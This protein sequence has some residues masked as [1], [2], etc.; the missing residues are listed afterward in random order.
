MST[1][2]GQ[3]PTLPARR[4]E[5]PLGDDS[6]RRRRALRVVLIKR[7]TS[8]TYAR[9]QREALPPS[10]SVRQHL[11]GT[12]SSR[13]TTGDSFGTLA[14]GR[15][16]L[17]LVELANSTTARTA[18]LCPAN[19]NAMMCNDLLQASVDANG[20]VATPTGRCWRLLCSLSYSKP[21]RCQ[22]EVGRA[23]SE[24]TNP[25]RRCPFTRS[26]HHHYTSG[27]P[28]VITAPA[29]PAA[30]VNSSAAPV[31]LLR[32]FTL[33]LAHSY[34]R[35]FHSGLA[36]SKSCSRAHSVKIPNSNLSFQQIH[37]V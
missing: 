35:L 6:A 4:D 37:H 30:E 14:P 33:S 25:S 23:K 22:I 11:C 9:R 3:L 27:L 34:S 20:I 12:V 36:P 29:S 31:Y 7:A 32:R 18:H 2:Y 21:Q 1:G 24:A 8:T 15:K 5:V 16:A 28:C 13:R 10:G 17:S 26:S 19:A